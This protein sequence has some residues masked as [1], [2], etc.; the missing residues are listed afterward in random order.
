MKNEKGYVSILAL[1]L[2]ILL[3]VLLVLGIDVARMQAI[4]VH[5]RH[6]LNLALRAA[7]AQIDMEAFLDPEDSKLIIVETDARVKFD[8]VLRDNLRLDENYRPYPSSVAEGKV[9]VSFFQ[10]VNN[11]PYYYTYGS[12]SENVDAV[13]CTGIIKVPI[14][15][16][17]FARFTT[18][19]G[20]YTDLYV[21]STVK[22]ETVE[23]GNDLE[24]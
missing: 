20:E 16:S 23:V 1:F 8:A 7:S 9:E 13:A 2:I 22:P 5:S 19:L 14:R 24:F 6:S 3:L 17:P 18:G 4:K 10:V 12:Y 21:H 15:L 11:P